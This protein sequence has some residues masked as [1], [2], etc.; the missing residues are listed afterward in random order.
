VLPD[1]KLTFDLKNPVLK[2]RLISNM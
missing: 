2:N 1:E